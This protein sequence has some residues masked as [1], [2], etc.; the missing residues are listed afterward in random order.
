MGINFKEIGVGLLG[1]LE[2]IV[3]PFVKSAVDRTVYGLLQTAE[4]KLGEER[5]KEIAAVFYPVIDV[6]IEKVAELSETELDD[7]AVDGAKEACERYAELKG[8]QLP[9]L[10]DD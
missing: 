3:K 4:Q 8:M 1:F 9:N 10:D 5:G 7:A 2:P 6:E